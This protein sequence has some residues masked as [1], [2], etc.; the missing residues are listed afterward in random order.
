MT[1]FATLLTP[2]DASPAIE[3][4]NTWR[5]RI[6]PVGEIAYQGR[7]LKFTRGYLQGLV[8]AW[9]DRAYDQVPLQFA[10]AANTHTNDPERTRGWITDMQVEPDGLYVTAELTQRGQRTLQDNPYLGV[11]ARIVEQFQRADGK[12]YPAAIQHVLGTLDPRIPGLGAWRSVD[13]ANE[14]SVVIDLSNLSFAGAQADATLN[15][16]ELAELMDAISEAEAEDYAD[17]S[18]DELS[19]AELN[20]LI[21]AAERDEHDAF[22]DFDAAFT[23]RQQAEQDRADA[24]AAAI[25][26]DTLHPVHRQ[27]DKIARAMHRAAQGVY[28]GQQAD[29]TAEQAGVEILLANGGHGPCG[30]LDDFGRCAS[31]Y[32][33]LGCAHDQATDWMAT[34]GG[35]PR[36]AYQASFANFAAGLNIDLAPRQVWD[37]PDD[38]D[39]PPQYM[40]Q[41]T[42]E[43]A[44]S[45]AHDWG[46]D[47]AAPGG[48]ETGSGFTD[49]LRPPGAPVSIQDELLA[50]MGY[51]MPAQDRPSYPGIGQLARDLGLK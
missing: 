42:V 33:E 15:D 16:R 12:F 32:H 25:L 38:A 50:G 37:D 45:L 1:A 43:L 30:P 24:R 44:H 10:D 23:A 7:T 51:E 8:A 2:V 41:Q 48:I 14:S 36:S 21:A 4:G 46:L 19:D 47:S 40:P 49:L 20:A 22:T 17:D 31:R 39:Q 18:A 34:E 26:E 11:S 13:M 28:D 6:L 35:P 3:L 9:R 27:E 5:K 29:F